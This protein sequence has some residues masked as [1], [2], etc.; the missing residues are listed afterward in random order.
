[1]LKIPFSR[2]LSGSNPTLPANCKYLQTKDL[3]HSL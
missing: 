2:V 3:L 1:M